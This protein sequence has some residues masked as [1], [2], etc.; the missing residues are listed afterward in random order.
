MAFQREKHFFSHIFIF[1]RVDDGYKK[2]D[3]NKIESNFFIQKPVQKHN[4]I[5]RLVFGIG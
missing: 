1:D 4:F 5:L 2:N 3:R